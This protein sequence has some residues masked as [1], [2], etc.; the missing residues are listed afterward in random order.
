MQIPKNVLYVSPTFT[1]SSPNHFKTVE[2][3]V[4]RAKAIA[5]AQMPVVIKV[6]PG[7]YP[8]TVT[9]EANIY[10]QAELGVSGLTVT[11]NGGVYRQGGNIA[12]TDKSNNFTVGQLFTA[13][14]FTGVVQ[15]EDILRL[16]SLGGGVLNIKYADAAIVEKTATFPET[17]GTVDITP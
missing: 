13:A 6:Y 1:L 8:E 7:V 11:E 17:T 16:I 4:A 10:L 5:N 9:L 15:I 12:Y 2:K 14:G 3:A